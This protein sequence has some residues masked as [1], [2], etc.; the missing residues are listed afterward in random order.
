MLV[1]FDLAIAVLLVAALLVVAPVIAWLG[2]GLVGVRWLVLGHRLTTLVSA[3]RWHS[4]TFEPRGR[5]DLVDRRGARDPGGMS[6]HRAVLQRSGKVI[7]LPRPHGSAVLPAEHPS[8]CP[9][10]VSPAMSSRNGVSSSGASPRSIRAHLRPP[11][12]GGRPTSFATNI[13]ASWTPRQRTTVRSRLRSRRTRPSTP[14]LSRKRTSSATGRTSPFDGRSPKPCKPAAMA[15]GRS[16]S[17][18]EELGAYRQAT[19]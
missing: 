16:I 10:S 11:R 3:H 2:A 17:D 14:N 18:L 1:R 15:R 12:S 9:S 8:T 5:G 7:C 13:S 19:P 6:A 4:L